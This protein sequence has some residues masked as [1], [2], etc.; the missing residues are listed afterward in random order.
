MLLLPAVRGGASASASPRTSTA[1]RL[2]QMRERE[3]SNRRLL[4]WTR[5]LHLHDVRSVK[6]DDSG[7]GVVHVHLRNLLHLL[8][9]VLSPRHRC[10]CRCVGGPDSFLPLPCRKKRLRLPRFPLGMTKVLRKQKCLAVSRGGE[11]SV[12]R[13]KEGRELRVVRSDA[14]ERGKLVVRVLG[15]GLVER[16]HRGRSAFHGDGSWRHCAWLRP[17]GPRPQEHRRLLSSRRQRWR[18]RGARLVGGDEIDHDRK[19]P[20][21]RAT[22][23]CRAAFPPSPSDLPNE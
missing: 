1:R 16:P 20:G 2:I 18:R 15:L 23:F 11:R 5:C 14:F 19:A 21:K 4:T 8:L 12:V 13:G 10:R 3:D 7:H 9:E 17:I 22:S 6:L